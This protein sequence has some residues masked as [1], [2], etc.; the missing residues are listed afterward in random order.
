MWPPWWPG[1]SWWPRPPARSGWPWARSCA[2][3]PRPPRSCC[4]GPCW[5]CPTWTRSAASCTGCCLACTSSCPT[6]PSTPSSTSTTPT[7]YRWKARC[8]RP[9]GSCSPRSLPSPP[10][11][12]TCWPAWPW[13]AS[14]PAAAPSPDRAG[15]ALTGFRGEAIGADGDLSGL[16]LGQHRLRFAVEVQDGGG[17]GVPGRDHGV[18]PEVPAPRVAHRPAQHRMVRIP[19]EVVAG[20]DLD[21]VTV[22]VEQVHVEGVGYAVPAGAALDPALQPQRAEDVADPQ[23][24]VRLVGE[25]PQVVQARP[26]AAGERH[27]VHGLLA[28]HPGGVE[29]LFVLD[30]LGQAEAEGTVILVA[31]PHVG[32]DDVEM[33]EPRDLG[34]APQVIPLLQALDVIGVEEQLNREA[35]R[36]LRADRLPHAGRD[37]GRYPRRAR[38]ERRVERLGQVQV[39]G[40]PDPE[41]EPPRRGP[42][43]RAQDQ[44]VVGELVVP[45]QVQRVRGVA[46][47]HEAEQVHPEPPGFVQV[48]DDELG[49]GGPDDIGRSRGFSR[50]SHGQAPNRGTCVSAS[51][52]WTIRDSV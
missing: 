32:D 1:G 24:L 46:A 2:A 42:R 44:A 37:P 29:R 30:R 13:P 31:G 5:S 14:L 50:P 4:C 26:V 43:A 10:W 34:A 35:E 18:T 38:S 8:Y 45:A 7:P 40:G 47:D 48:G 21:P 20:V 33:V 36:V 12:C 9:A 28:E 25:E 22:R 39:T 27:V 17:F 11:P 3:G 19:G 49:V 41:G 52:T 16:P 51:G 6:P 15:L 23:H